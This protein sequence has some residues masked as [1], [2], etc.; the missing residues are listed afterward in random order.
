MK[1]QSAEQTA[2]L[3]SLRIAYKIREI[4]PGKKK[5][6]STKTKTVQTKGQFVKEPLPLFNDYR[7]KAKDHDPL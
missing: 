5:E 6:S 2:P 3:P 4:R 7:F 1:Q